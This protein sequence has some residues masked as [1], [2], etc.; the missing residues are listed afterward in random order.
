MMKSNRTVDRRWFIATC[1]ASFGA[2]LICRP[3]RE[4]LARFTSIR[5][6][7]SR[8]G[9]MIRIL[10]KSRDPTR[11]IICESARRKGRTSRTQHPRGNARGRQPVAQRMPV[12]RIP[13]QFHAL[14]GVVREA[15]TVDRQRDLGLTGPAGVR[16]R[17]GSRA[18]R[19]VRDGYAIVHA[20]GYDW[21]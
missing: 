11:N 4:S 7:D 1:G 3:W 9:R 8:P 2:A 12:G 6:S 17:T 14:Q 15:S 10:G 18:S 20:S 19:Q 16:N 13:D 5:S 21:W